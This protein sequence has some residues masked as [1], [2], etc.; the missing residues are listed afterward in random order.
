MTIEDNA[1]FSEIEPT[2]VVYALAASPA[3]DRDGICFAARGSG[4][5]RSTDGG[6]T[7]QLA[8]A[9]LG[10]DEAVATPAVAISPDFPSDHTVFA[11][12]AGAILRSYDGGQTWYVSSLPT[13][14]PVVSC[15]AVSPD[16]VRDGV[17]FAGTMEDGVF[18]SS[19]RGDHWV[20]WN[21]GLLD[22]HVMA[23]ALSPAFA[24]DETLFA[25]VESGIFR[26][27]NGGRAWREVPF[28]TD[29][30]PVLSLALSPGFKQDGFLLA[31]T[32]EHGLWCS[33]DAGRSWSRL[34]EGMIEG[35]V[36]AILLAADFP[37]T[38]MILVVTS[39][40]V[41]VSSDA[42]K[43]WDEVVVDLPA[44][45]SVVAVSAPLGLKPGAPLLLGLSAG[46]VV[47]S[48]I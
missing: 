41:R 10:L 43:T 12:V 2:D 31:G 37:R 15:L 5:Y 40:G 32:E 30:A 46:A 8:Y 22:L 23:L 25:G 20:R 3:F 27:T 35:S 16:Y 29:L 17:V 4:L 11:G 48:V 19:D 26:S 28:P 34:G 18:R 14:P 9:S 36:N 39:E 45:D 6:A 21:F 44:D 38:P 1:T 47:R 24:A 33:H 13:P 7:W 42:G